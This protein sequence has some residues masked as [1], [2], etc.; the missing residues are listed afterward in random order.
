MSHH[1]TSRMFRSLRTQQAMQHG[2]EAIAN[3]RVHDPDAGPVKRKPSE[4]VEMLRS[5]NPVPPEEIISPAK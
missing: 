1:Q 5:A 2:A 3:G 4:L